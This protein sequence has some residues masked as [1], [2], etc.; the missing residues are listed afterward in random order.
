MPLISVTLDVAHHIAAGLASG[1]LERVGGVVREME[2]KQVVAWL[3]EGGK[4][5]D[6]P[7]LADGFL[8]SLLNVSSGGLTSGGFGALDLVVSSH[9]HDQVM[10][11]L[12]RL[13][14]L[15]QL[16]AG[17]GVTNI[18][19]SALS[20]AIL[21]NR[22]NRLEAKIEGLYKFIEEEIQKQ[23]QARLSRA[24]TAA[25]NA[26]NMKHFENKGKQAHKAIDHFNNVRSFMLAD[27][28]K[29]LK[30]SATLSDRVYGLVQAIQIDSMLTRLHLEIDELDS[31][32]YHLDQ[33]VDEHR[34]RVREMVGICLGDDRQ[35][36]FLDTEAISKDDLNRFVAIE[37]WLHRRDNDDNDWKSNTVD[38]PLMKVL[39]KYRKAL[40]NTELF[41]NQPDSGLRA[42]ALRQNEEAIIPP[43]D[44]LLFAELLIEKYEGLEG[45]Q[46]ELKAIA[47]LST[48]SD[49]QWKQWQDEQSEALKRAKIN[50]ADHNDYVLLVDEE[51]LDN[52][53]RLSAR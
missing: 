19:V 37:D 40:R 15:Q 48:S 52:L 36:Y 20:L 17:I 1:Q 10:Q 28:D 30:E 32:K 21:L 50:L 4:I 31:A 45:L 2:N 38:S 27:L 16:S 44:R 46:A 29:V 34:C 18:A 33:S 3:R 25:Q 6:N 43:V 51:Y 39:E 5:A 8:R 53:K 26:F 49:G 35:A 41:P 9:R 23:K 47:S 24:T 22:L 12:R 11:Q 13:E 7:N 14:R 42:R